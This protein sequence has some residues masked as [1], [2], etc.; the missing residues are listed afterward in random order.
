MRRTG[1]A[2]SAS[3]SSEAGAS[4]SAQPHQ[5]S[6]T[7]NGRTM[8]GALMRSH[9]NAAN[10]RAPARVGVAHGAG[11]AR[12]LAKPLCSLKNNCC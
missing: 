1:I 3:S 8:C 12:L 2:M 7:R 11:T 10:L 5:G 9:T 6:A 4:M